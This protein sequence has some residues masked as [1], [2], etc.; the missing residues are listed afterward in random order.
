MKTLGLYF[1]CNNAVHAR[2]YNLC[3]NTNITSAK[4]VLEVATYIL[5][6]DCFH[7]IYISL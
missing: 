5:S 4:Q 2:T 7:L 6:H 3:D 1:P